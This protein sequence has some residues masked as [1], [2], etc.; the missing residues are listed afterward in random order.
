MPVT[1]D[2]VA[3]LRAYLADDMD[4]H[5]QLYARLD[6]ET[7]RVGYVALVTAAF[8]AAVSQRFAPADT[9]G[10][11]EFVADLR[12]RSEAL[13]ESIDP[14]AAERLIR[15]V[16]D[17]EDTDLGGNDMGRLIIVLLAGLIA[18]RKLSAAELDEFLAGA[19]QLADRWLR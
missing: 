18:D 13:A 5:R 15:A 9:T 3:V 11:V 4:E 6:R 14:G 8:I 19:R 10:V 17:E 2:Q 1:D 7:A 16:L 12:S